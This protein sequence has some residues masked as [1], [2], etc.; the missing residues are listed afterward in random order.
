MTDTEHI[1]GSNEED[2]ILQKIVKGIYCSSVRLNF[3][4]EIV[5]FFLNNFDMVIFVHSVS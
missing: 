4:L 3:A 1:F 5:Q 2:C